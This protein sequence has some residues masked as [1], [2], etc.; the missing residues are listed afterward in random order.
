MEIQ[1]DTDLATLSTLELFAVQLDGIR[2]RQNDVVGNAAT[3]S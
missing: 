2:V 3:K 1:R